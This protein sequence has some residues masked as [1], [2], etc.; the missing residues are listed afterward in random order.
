VLDEDEK[1]LIDSIQNLNSSIK[2]VLLQTV[3]HHNRSSDTVESNSLILGRSMDT[4]KLA[5]QNEIQMKK[6]TLDIKIDS[7]SK[8]L[9]SIRKLIQTGIDE[10][11][12][13]DAAN[14]KKMCAI[15][16]DREVEI[17]MIPCGHTSCAGCFKYNTTSKCMHCRSVI[18]K[19]VKLFFSM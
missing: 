2:V 7:L 6:S 16:F 3:K 10:L 19:H 8:K 9:N 4:V 14:N 13:K 12:D 1:A 17:A 11:L 15:C 5:I 18:Q